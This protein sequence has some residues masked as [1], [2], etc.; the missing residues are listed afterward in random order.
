MPPT[1]LKSVTLGCQQST[2]NCREGGQLMCQGESYE[3]NLGWLELD[4]G[5]SMC[6]ELY[7]PL[8]LE[9]WGVA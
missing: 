3:R 6:W 4:Y 1:W 8:D 7:W 5:S 2:V 9:N